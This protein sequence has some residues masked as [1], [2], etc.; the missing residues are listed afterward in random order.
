MNAGQIDPQ[1]RLGHS[2]SFSVEL[3][4]EE[5]L[6]DQLWKDYFHSVNIQ[7]RK[8]MKLH[9]QYVPK[10]YWRYMNEKAL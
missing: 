4:D 7:A 3:D 9:I 5:L 8:N 1:V 6:Y 2:Q 10:R